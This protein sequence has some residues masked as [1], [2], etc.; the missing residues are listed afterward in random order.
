[1]ADQQTNPQGESG[2]RTER[3]IGRA[4]SGLFGEVATEPEQEPEQD[5]A[6]DEGTA[7][8]DEADE[9]EDASGDEDADPEDEGASEA[10]PFIVA[11]VDGKDIPVA[12][13]EEAIP[14]VQKGLHYT[15]EMQKLR[16]EQRRFDSEREQIATGLRHKETQYT[17]A[18]QTL[19]DTYGHVL[20]QEAPDWSSAE[21]QKLKTEKPS[22]YLALREQWDQLGAIKSELGRINREK[23]EA[24]QKQ[25]QGWVKTQQEALAEKAPEW[26]DPAKRQQDFALIRDYAGS[27][28]VGE[29]ELGNLFDHR[30]WLILRDAARYRQAE[31]SGKTK[32]EVVKTKTAEPGTGKNVN[33]GNRD[34]RAARDRLSKTGDVRAAGDVFQ[35]LMS[36]KRK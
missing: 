10:G 26:A 3:E 9:N 30:Y 17:A 5:T 21:V 18:L 14:L 11:K 23:Q 33:Q 27:L 1:V 19:H 28:G 29:Q 16:D 36:T 32:R 4:M 13:K 15:Q 12:T 34:F 35:Q 7:D 24:Q 6:P 20:G 31:A 8:L 22:E 25:F 2:P